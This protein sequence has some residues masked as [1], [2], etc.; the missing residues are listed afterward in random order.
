[1]PVEGIGVAI[2]IAAISACVGARVL[3][4]GAREKPIAL[5]DTLGGLRKIHAVPTPRIGGI[6]VALGI[7]LGGLVL[8]GRGGGWIHWLLLLACVA[9]A[10]AWGLI[11]DLSKRGAVLPRLVLPALAGAL[12]FILFDARLTE[13]DIPG[14]D[15]LLVIHAVAFL[16]TLFAVTGVCHSIN[17]IDGLNGLAGVTGVLAAIGLAIV[18]A[19][20]DDAFIFAAACVLA[21]SLAG[22]LVVN[23][24]SGRIF[25]GDGGA[26]LVGLLLAEL[27]VLLVHRNSEVSPW[28]PPVL[29]A[30]PI[31]ET[32][33][34]MYR[35][36][37]RGE[38]TSGAD[39]LHLHQ[40]VYRRIVR[41][42]G[43]S[44]RS[45]DKAARNSVASLLMWPLPFVCLLAAVAFWDDSPMLQVLGI[46]YMVGYAA[47]YR[48]FVRFQLPRWAVIRAPARDAGDE[49]DIAGMA[50]R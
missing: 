1:L 47:L 39:A 45:A 37:S 9:P 16:F 27:A 18:A 13:L 49:S 19:R 7:V 8:W 17:V 2:A 34:S 32:M 46:S 22:F 26:Y 24:P 11:E 41:W 4:G 31:W 6:A 14:V 15:R 42:R 3:A 43:F 30:Y 23:Y 40:L 50:G 20:V 12:G 25:L 48:V 33:F 29:L 21:G 5:D 35:R 10:F 38:S 28:F 44:H 36:R